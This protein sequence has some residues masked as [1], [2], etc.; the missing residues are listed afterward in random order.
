MP[1]DDSD[2]NILDGIGDAIGDFGV[3][4]GWKGFLVVL[5]LVAIVCL[6]LYID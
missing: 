1:W 5:F 3:W 2:D 6:W 4:L